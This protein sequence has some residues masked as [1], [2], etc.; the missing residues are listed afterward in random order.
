MQIFYLLSYYEIQQGLWP[1]TLDMK[2][3]PAYVYLFNNAV[4]SLLCL[5]FSYPRGFQL[6]ITKDP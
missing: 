3:Y 4:L 6:V 1:F 2:R 5:N